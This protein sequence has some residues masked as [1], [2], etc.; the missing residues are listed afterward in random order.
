M[1]VF[2]SIPLRRCFQQRIYWWPKLPR[3]LLGF[4]VKRPT[5]PS[6]SS[7]HP[8]LF[9]VQLYPF[10]AVGAR[11]PIVRGLPLFSLWLSVPFSS[12]HPRIFLVDPTYSPFFSFF[13]PRC[14]HVLGFPLHLLFAFS[15]SFLDFFNPLVF[16][17]IPFYKP[18]FLTGPPQ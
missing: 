4:S 15:P 8:H 13:L 3:T 1:T 6:L 11:V 9:C 2:F 18:E 5:G 16:F 10:L 12:T 7:T 14:S 17:L